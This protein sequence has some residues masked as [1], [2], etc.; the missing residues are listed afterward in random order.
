MVALPQAFVRSTAPIHARPLHRPRRVAV[1]LNANARKV[2]EGTLRWIRTVVP[3]E[4]LFLSRSLDE[5]PAICDML[6]ARRYDAVLW[7]GG[8]GTL[9]QGVQRLLVA[10]EQQGVAMPEWGVLRLG[11][12]NAVAETV[13]SA[14]PTADGLALDLSRARTPARRKELSLLEVEGKPT[15]FCG[16]GMDAQILDDHHRL[17]D[18][19]KTAGLAR[20][21]ESAN[22]RY[23]LS[24]AGRSIPRFVASSRPEVV[25]INRGTPALK[26]D[27]DGKTVGAPIPAG[28][29][30]WRGPATLAS[31][32]TVPYYGLALKMFPHAQ[33]QSD[34]FQLRLSDVS[35][36]EALLNL[37]KVWRGA[38]QGNHVH[39]FLADEVELLVS[40]PAP[41]QSGGDLV[42]ERTRM[43]IKLSPTKLSMI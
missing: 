36:G 14:E 38:Y 11:T 10:A 32:S 42:G 43:R 24:V 37:P 20:A 9:V 29:V 34:R 41:F 18:L 27:V 17:V 21:I 19:L 23:F 6:L 15:V 8:D 13:G 26:I 16:F 4:D 33:K 3:N 25:A 31:A 12:G 1:V 5:L 7:G 35:A 28:R 30:L 40:R 22:A 2:D 39:D